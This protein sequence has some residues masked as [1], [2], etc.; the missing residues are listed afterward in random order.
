MQ[1]TSQEPSLSSIQSIAEAAQDQVQEGIE[2]EAITTLVSI[3]SSSS[4]ELEHFSSD[5]GL[6]DAAE[7]CRCKCKNLHAWRGSSEF[8]RRKYCVVVCCACDDDDL[9]LCM[10][11]TSR[12]L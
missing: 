11:N 9:S 7:V 4:D 2:P 5:L 12:A 1:L 6:L 3:I 10:P 8:V